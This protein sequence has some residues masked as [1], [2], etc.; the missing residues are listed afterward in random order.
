V[1]TGL[2]TSYPPV[3]TGILLPPMPIW[4]PIIAIVVALPGCAN[5]CVSLYDRFL[6]DRVGK[7]VAL[8]AGKLGQWGLWTFN[9]ISLALLSAVIAGTWVYPPNAPQTRSPTPAHQMNAPTHAGPPPLALARPLPPGEADRKLQVINQ[10][11]DLFGPGMQAIVDQGPSL[12]SGAWN[13]FKDQKNNSTYAADLRA[14]IEMIRSTV[15][16][17]QELRQS[18]PEYSDISSA[19]GDHYPLEASA[20]NFRQA[21]ELMTVYLSPSIENQHFEIL[22]RPFSAP[23]ERDIRK[24]SEWRNNVQNQLTEIRRQTVR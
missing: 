24:F 20:D 13:A 18:H 15:R 16:K 4:I 5:A 6:A 14:Y 8:P 3:A 10:A 2:K 12:L 1:V 11:A 21:Y 22:I 9:L 17:T 19:I 23:F 7:P